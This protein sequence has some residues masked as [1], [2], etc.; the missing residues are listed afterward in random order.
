M[1]TSSF[2]VMVTGQI[3]TADFPSI[4]SLYCKYAFSFGPD[5]AQIGGVHEGI[6][7]TCE[8]GRSSDRITLA[9]PLEATFSSTS[10]FRW[11]Q[12]VLSCYGPDFFNH[13]V[14]R[15]YGAVH[16]PATPG[17]SL[18]II[19]CKESIKVTDDSWSHRCLNV[20]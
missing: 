6:S 15:G 11:P 9:L 5:W 4:S 20:T 7:A 8:R 2:L 16:I 3:E 10:P 13:D 12:L 1:A 18:A 17:A 14:I 19:A